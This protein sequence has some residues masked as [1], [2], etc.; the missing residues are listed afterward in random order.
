MMSL[1]LIYTPVIV[2]RSLVRE[3]SIEYRVLA[4]AAERETVVVVE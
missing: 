2:L 1:Q 4:G 3:L